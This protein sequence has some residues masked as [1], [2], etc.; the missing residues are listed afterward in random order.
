LVQGRRRMFDARSVTERGVV[1]HVHKV[2]LFSSHD[3]PRTPYSVQTVYFFPF[4]WGSSHL[5][6]MRR[7]TGLRWPTVSCEALFNAKHPAFSAWFHIS[8]VYSIP[9][10]ESRHG[11]GRVRL[12]G[13]RYF[14][15]VHR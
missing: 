11:P 10:L 9:A 3:P 8:E 7:G 2:S 13:P 6:G 1:V 14:V 12:A 5:F 15:F 4:G